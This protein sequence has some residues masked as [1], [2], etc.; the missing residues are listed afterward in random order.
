M[1]SQLISLVLFVLLL[2]VLEKVRSLLKRTQVILCWCLSGAYAN[3]HLN[4]EV[5]K[6]YNTLALLDQTY[7]KNTI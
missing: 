2:N 7:T 3:F 4:F 6:L 1:D 5:L